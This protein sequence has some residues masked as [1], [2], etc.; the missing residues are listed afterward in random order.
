MNT[1]LVLMD[2]LNKQYL[3]AYN[4]ETPVKTPNIKAFAEDSCTFENHFLSSA[5][6]MPARRDFLTGRYSFLERCW[7]PIEAYDKTMTQAFRKRGVFSHIVTDHCHYMDRGGENYLQEYST[8]DYVRGQEY[9]PWVSRVT[10]MPA[11]EHYGHVFPQ[12]ELNHTA[13]VEDEEDYPTPRTF[14]AA[15]EWLEENKDEDN[16][17]LQV[18]VFDPHEPFDTPKK[19]KDMY[20]DDYA[21]PRFNCSSYEAVTEPPEAIEHLR[22]RYAACMTMTDAWFGKLISKLK[23]LNLYE[24]TLIILTTDHG[25]LLGEHGFTGKNFTHG[26]NQLSNIPMMIRYPGGLRKGERVKDITQMIDLPV[27][28]LDYL[29][30]E[31]PD[32]MLGTSILPLFTEK[33]SVTKKTALFG[34]FGGPVNICDG[35]YTYFR[36]AVNEDNTPLYNYCSTPTTLLK[37]MAQENRDSIEMGRYLSY[38]D[39]PVYKIPAPFPIGHFKSSKYV[40]ESLLFDY[41]NDPD[42]VN[43]IDDP[44]LEQKMI[45]KLLD[46][47]QWAGAPD[48]QYTRLGLQK[49]GRGR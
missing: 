39:F 45:G 14:K 5:P 44:E 9:D 6:C 11:F 41:V 29:D 24:D 38:T 13:Y 43:P 48:E 23:E 49:P 27:T 20:P 35:K 47:M 7:G 21:G 34:W 33:K 19:Y 10:P 42:Q 8:W 3:E 28:L 15:C 37:F 40:R 31:V 30:C 18:E 12:Y 1:I 16:Y 4:P 36:A 22:N 17:F 2:S 26:Y 46:L 32:T 25:H